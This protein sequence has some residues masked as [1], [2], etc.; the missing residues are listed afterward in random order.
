MRFFRAYSL[1]SCLSTVVPARSG[2]RHPFAV[3]ALKGLPRRL[4]LR[5]P[6]SLKTNRSGPR[7][8]ALRCPVGLTARPGKLRAEENLLVSPSST[9]WCGIGFLLPENLFDSDQPQPSTPPASAPQRASLDLRCLS[10]F[11]CHRPTPGPGCFVMSSS[12]PR[13]GRTAAACYAA[14]IPDCRMTWSFMP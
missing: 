13:S 14:S 1:R 4:S 3:S 5:S 6:A 2:T 9:R 12:P 7:E 11:P 10:A 8:L